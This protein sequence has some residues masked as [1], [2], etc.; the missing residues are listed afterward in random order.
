MRYTIWLP[1][2]V[3]VPDD[4]EELISAEELLQSVCLCVASEE[5]DSS[6]NLDA[7][8]EY[9]ALPKMLA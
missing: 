1:V 2:V 9:C 8:A 3:P 6:V 7:K 5:F 4:D